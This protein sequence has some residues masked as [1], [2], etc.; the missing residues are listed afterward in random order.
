MYCDAGNYISTTNSDLDLLST[1][2][3]LASEHNIVASNSQDF[4]EERYSSADLMN[5][6][7]L[8]A[9]SRK[10]NQ[11]RQNSSFHYTPFLLINFLPQ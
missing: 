1:Y 10:T 8:D 7:S 2:L 9:K 11:Y 6:L 3:N 4:I 5:L